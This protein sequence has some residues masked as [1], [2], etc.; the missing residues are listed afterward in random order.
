MILFQL[1]RLYDTD[2]GGQMFMHGQQNLKKRQL[3]TISRYY[4]TTPL[5]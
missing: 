3:G 1:Q 5:T 2:Q 4:T